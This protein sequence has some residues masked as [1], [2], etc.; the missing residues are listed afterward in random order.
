M[1]KRSHAKSD[2]YADDDDDNDNSEGSFD[3]LS[4]ETIPHSKV[5]AV[6]KVQFQQAGAPLVDR[7]VVEIG[8]LRQRRLQEGVLPD[9]G[10]TRRDDNAADHAAGIRTLYGRDW[11]DEAIAR[12]RMMDSDV[13]FRFAFIVA[14]GYNRALNLLIQE[15]EVTKE[16][17]RR[18]AAATEELLRRRSQQQDTRGEQDRVKDLRRQID[19]LT[20]KVDVLTR[21]WKSLRGAQEC[22]ERAVDTLNF[23]QIGFP[24]E[25]GGGMEDY[26]HIFT[27]ITKTL[28]ARFGPRGYESGQSAFATAIG[29]LHNHTLASG[30]GEQAIVDR[31]RNDM[32]NSSTLAF[33]W[34]VLFGLFTISDFLERIAKDAVS[35]FG[36]DSF[37]AKNPSQ[38]AADLRSLANIAFRQTSRLNLLVLDD[39]TVYFWTAL[40]TLIERSGASKNKI[41]Q[42]N[43]KEAQRIGGGGQQRRQQAALVNGIPVVVD[44]REEDLRAAIAGQDTLVV[45]RDKLAQYSRN[46][47]TNTEQPRTLLMLLAVLEPMVRAAWN[48]LFYTKPQ[49]DNRRDEEAFAGGYYDDG[50]VF[51]MFDT[52]AQPPAGQSDS[53]KSIAGLFVVA[54]RLMAESKVAAPPTP[55]VD[56]VR[57]QAFQQVQAADITRIK[58]AV[59]DAFPVSNET[60]IDYER[61]VLESYARTTELLRCLAEALK[62]KAQFGL[63]S[64]LT[65]ADFA[66]IDAFLAAPDSAEAEAPF[67]RLFRH[68]YLS[69]DDGPDRQLVVYRGDFDRVAA[70]SQKQ[71][72]R[73]ALQKQVADAKYVDDQRTANKTKG[74]LVEQEK[75][76]TERI[77]NWTRLS[78][79]QEQELLS[80]IIRDGVGSDPEVLLQTINT[81]YMF[82]TEV[83]SAALTFA[84]EH[85]TLYIPCLARAYSGQELIESE[86][87]QASYAQLVKAEL[88]LDEAGNP[89]IFKADKNEA[90]ARMRV[91]SPLESLREHA[92]TDG[93]VQHWASC[94]CAEVANI[95]APPVG[96]GRTY[97]GGSRGNYPL[98]P[99]LF[100]PPGAF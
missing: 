92:R 76:I 1:S 46:L 71:F 14:G 62:I 95:S 11:L 77:A 37:Y 58:T 28:T 43:Q 31:L 36:A 85:V 90:R 32:P 67:I 59:K 61:R 66:V 26:A 89:Q 78:L 70:Q 34:S 15:S 50:R 21:A 88:R 82:N 72:I 16:T 57:M 30:G 56:V 10:S 65:P 17:R 2:F 27:L 94:G 100:V 98:A 83:Y 13:N 81:G 7:T 74:L 54:D 8:P 52:V 9:D 38:Y 5:Q 86:R 44:V 48:S 39:V 60:K 96:Y 87:Y 99:S 80:A 19:E 69:F 41:N 49:L 79:Q 45:D 68:S 53:F 84:N 33:Y 35:K 47:Y 51:K 6:S 22:I 93:S 23:K 63:T 91:V 97:A 42:P 75:N 20:A 40:N 24:A 25:N 4:E 3:D 12:R 64:G 73:A 18:I 55:F 29:L